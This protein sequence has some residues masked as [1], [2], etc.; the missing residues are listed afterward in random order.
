MITNA[1]R[2]PA[3]PTFMV[4]RSLTTLSDRAQTWLDT[5]IERKVEYLRSVS[6][7]FTAVAADMVREGL[8]AKGVDERYSGEEWVA[9]PVSLLRT[10]RLLADTLGG[11]ARTG[12]VPLPRSAVMAA[13]DGR[14]AVQVI[15]A[16][17][18]ESR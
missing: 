7:R 18:R 9:G 16:D 12:S 3:T 1:G 17:S 2:F 15:P 11:I 5:P 8:A 4:D 14:V 6:R 13:P 10:T